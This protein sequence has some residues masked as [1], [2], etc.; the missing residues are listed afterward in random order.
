MTVIC[1]TKLTNHF[2]PRWSKSSQNKYKY[3]NNNLGL[4]ELLRTSKNEVFHVMDCCYNINHLA[5]QG[6][7]KPKLFSMWAP[8][9][10]MSIIFYEIHTKRTGDGEFN[11]SRHKLF[12]FSKTPQATL[13]KKQS[14]SRNFQLPNVH[15]VSTYM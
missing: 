4:R 12:P 8:Y 3:K 15:L 13:H 6:C 9:K 7:L 11:S 10:N 2:L 1:Y 14:F 5:K